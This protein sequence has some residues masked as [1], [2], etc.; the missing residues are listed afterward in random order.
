MDRRKHE[1]LEFAYGSGHVNPMKATDPGLVYDAWE[2]DYINF[3]C[4]QGYNTS[5]LRLV[6]GD[7]SV[8]N[9]TEPGRA[10]DLNYPSFSL[11]VDDGQQ[12]AGVFTRTVT[13][14]GAPN[15]TYTVGMYFPATLTV[16]VEPSVLSFSALG[17]S[18]SFTVKVDGPVIF[19]QPI[20]SG[21]IW[22]SD[23]VHTVRSPLVVYTTLPGGYDFYSVSQK[24]PAFKGSSIYHKNGI[25]GN[26]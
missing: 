9:S 25:L 4:K 23:G 14:V 11:A 22:W 20:I 6:T 24:K 5:T 26:H 12:I 2:G 21:A 17:E 13:N 16:T 7:D 3:L 8:C 18:K 19:Q 10:W 15:S 1:D